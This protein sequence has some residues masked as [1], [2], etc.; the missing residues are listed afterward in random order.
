CVTM[1]PGPNGNVPVSA[2]NAYYNY[3]PQFEPALACAVIFGILTAVHVAQ[4]FI[5]KKKY[6]WVIIMGA[7]WETLAFI[8][9]TLGTKDQQVV[10]YSIAWTLL[11]LLAPL[12]INAYAYMTFAR[13]VQYWHPQQKV[14]LRARTIGMWFVL[15]DIVSFIIQAAGGVMASPGG[16]PEQIK[17]GLD[18]YTGGTAL[19][20]FFIFI[21]IGL[22]IMFQR[23][24]TKLGYSSVGYASETGG[25]A[26]KSYKPLLFALYGTLLFITVR[27]MFRIVEF[28]KGFGPDNPLPFNEIYIYV[29]D[30]LP[31]M[32][33]LLILA[34][35]H[36][37]RYLVG[38][39]SEFP[40]I[41][42]KEKK[43][44]KMARKE[45]K[46]AAKE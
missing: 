28:A 26:K 3:D 30:C 36:P 9:H 44:I 20:Q 27:I 16:E 32:I 34:I 40:K 21:F 4:A 19:Q 8:I 46:R 33:A 10:A 13:M 2:C 41:S 12:W 43:A 22:M 25:V 11:F 23:Q 24:V 15:A 31:M 45:E 37:G 14:F 35:F 1:V 6:S 29:L 39:E 18:I 17:R 5:L 38:P 42:R 7:L